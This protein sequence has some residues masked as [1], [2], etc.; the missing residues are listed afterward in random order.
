MLVGCVKPAWQLYL[1]S[2]RADKW[3]LCAII[4]HSQLYKTGKHLHPSIYREKWKIIKIT[5]ISIEN[6][7]APD[8]L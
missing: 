2:V 1:G 4:W 5:L 8:P 3:V 6:Q 7:E